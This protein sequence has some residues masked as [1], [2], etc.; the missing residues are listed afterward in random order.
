MAQA[1][2]GGSGSVLV[3][4][5]ATPYV[6]DEPCLTF[7][8]HPV[9]TEIIPLKLK[10]FAFSTV[11]RPWFAILASLTSTDCSPESFILDM[12]NLI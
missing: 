2:N 8:F 11:D 1:W 5:L 10:H 12:F 6:N 4:R 3:F 9:K 7:F